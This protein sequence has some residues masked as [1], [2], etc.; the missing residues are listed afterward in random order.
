VR[1][2]TAGT[3]A[4]LAAP[5]AAGVILVAPGLVRV[6]GEGYAAAATPLRVLAPA[7]LAL[8]M[9]TVLL[10]ALVAAGRARRLPV[11]TAARVAAAAV[12]AAVLIPR[13]GAT[14]AAAGFL[15]SELL[16]L[17]LAARACGAAGFEVP[18]GRSLSAALGMTAPM[19]AAVAIAGISLVES[20]VVGVVTYV[21]TLAVASRWAPRLVSGVGL[22]GRAGRP[23][24]EG[25]APDPNPIDLLFR[26][27]LRQRSRALFAPRSRV[28]HL[29][30][31]LGA[32][33]LDGEHLSVRVVDVTPGSFDLGSRRDLDGAFA[34]PGVFDPPDLAT[35][36]PALAGALRSGAPVLLCLGRRSPAE[37]LGLRE[38][39]ARL[40]P[41]FIWRGA[42]AL[43][44]LVP[45]ESR[46][47]WVRG[48]PQ[49][50]G[51]LAAVEDLVRRWPLLRARGDYVA[52]EVARR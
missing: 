46:Q 32:D 7:I 17:V 27:V 41:D 45:A 14:G 16:L 5:A 50:F 31:G 36:G 52:L 44:L 30:R 40:G 24:T 42:F 1:R 12:L 49:A 20:I 23:V 25:Q 6:L 15:L 21:L 11:L 19:V 39:R 2:R 34:G 33:A 22:G 29:T 48:H 37:S 8:F 38:A 3:A 10:H 28:V 51:V 47:G 35:W 18:V 26:H 4:L 9:N 13:F 43:G